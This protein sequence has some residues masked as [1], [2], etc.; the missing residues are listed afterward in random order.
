MPEMI[1]QA[2]SIS[3]YTLFVVSFRRVNVYLK[4]TEMSQ[5]SS[6]VDRKTVFAII[7]MSRDKLFHAG[8]AHELLVQVNVHC[9]YCRFT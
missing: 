3:K 4:G 8:T 7:E 5:S 1:A 6:G 2:S 9:S